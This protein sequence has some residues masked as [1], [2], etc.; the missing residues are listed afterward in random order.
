MLN[1]RK[2]KMMTGITL[3]I[4]GSI[5]FG[6]LLVKDAMNGAG[7]ACNTVRPGMM[8]AIGFFVDLI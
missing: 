8:V 4:L 5:V 3:R 2:K 1:K 7:L 6:P